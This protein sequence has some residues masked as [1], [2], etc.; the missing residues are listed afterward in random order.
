MTK[1][2]DDL[3]KFAWCGTRNHNWSDFVEE[4]AEKADTENWGCDNKI[5]VNY[6]NHTFTN[7]AIAVNGGQAEEEEYFPISGE[8]CCFNTGLFTTYLDSIYAYFE[9][10]RMDHGPKWFLIGFKIK[11]DYEL[12]SFQKLPKRMDYFN[13]PSLLVFNPN[14]EI[15]TN[16]PHILG[17]DRNIERL[18][19]NFKK[20]YNKFSMIQQLEGAI[21]MA[22]KRIMANYTLA[23][24]QYYQGNLQLL[25]P[26]WFTDNTKADL[27]LTLTRMDD[28]YVGRTCL[29][30]DMAYNNARLIAK[31]DSSWLSPEN[32]AN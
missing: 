23:V 7:M 19:E 16:T 4:L 10:N 1:I 5:L 18:P 27:A 15:R 3:F 20:E 9:L 8:K 25:L 29:T 6:I 14:L 30:Y 28:L 13:D 21:G 2:P 31:P 11:S 22:K 17:D 12:S 24:P 26:L 32:I